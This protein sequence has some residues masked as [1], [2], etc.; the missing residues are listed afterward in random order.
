MQIAKLK[1]F[2]FINSIPEQE[3]RTVKYLVAFIL[4]MAL[5]YVL[6]L[7]IINVAVALSR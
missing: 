4:Y 7:G 1:V 6:G 5:C 3:R 2:I